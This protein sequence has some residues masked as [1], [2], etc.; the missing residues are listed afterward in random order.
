MHSISELTIGRVF[1]LYLD[2]QARPPKAKISV[3]V[4]ISD[5]GSEFATVFINSLINM[6]FINSPEL[7]ALQVEIQ[8]GGA[9]KFINH[10]SYIDCSSLKTRFPGNVIDEINND[11]GEMHGLLPQEDL[12]RV[13]ELIKNADSISPYYK[14]LYN[15]T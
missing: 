11:H 10:S 2:D 14:M 9:R 5:D 4:G 7:E 1:E 6:N 3:I 8:P 15:I 13:I 12:R